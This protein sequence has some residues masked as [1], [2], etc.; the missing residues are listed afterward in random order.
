MRW[1]RNWI[2][3]V[4]HF[5][6]LIL[7]PR[8]SETPIKFCILTSLID[9]LNLMPAAHNNIGAF[10]CLDRL[11]F[12]LAIAQI[13]RSIYSNGIKQI[14]VLKIHERRIVCNKSFSTKM[15][16]W[17]VFLI[18]RTLKTSFYILHELICIDPFEC[19]GNYVNDEKTS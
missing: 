1:K 3:F 7:P 2:A 4:W 13:P 8:N 17:F 10:C 6:L 11:V 16:H 14:Y 5:F 9:S 18:L 19:I 12:G 15:V